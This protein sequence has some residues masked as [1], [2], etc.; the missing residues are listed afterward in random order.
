V[1]L[2]GWGLGGRKGQAENAPV[3]RPPGDGRP[4]GNARNPVARSNRLE[5]RSALTISM[6]VAR[7]T[8]LR[9]VS[10]VGVPVNNRAHVR[11]ELDRP[12]L[13]AQPLLASIQLESRSRFLGMARNHHSRSFSRRARPIDTQTLS[14]NRLAR[15]R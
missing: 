8:G 7:R 12:R 13:G 4:I 9:I 10:L 14:F 5:L 3:S 11:R 1:R 15:D 6:L 2:D